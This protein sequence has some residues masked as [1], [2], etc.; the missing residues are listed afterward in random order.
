MW[1][2]IAISNVL[3]KRA[4]PKWQNWIKIA[5]TM[6]IIRFVSL[7]WNAVSRNFCYT[8]ITSLLRPGQFSPLYP[9]T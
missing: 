4:I 9:V 5:A 8:D 6:Y 2:P 1:L 7:L 3:L